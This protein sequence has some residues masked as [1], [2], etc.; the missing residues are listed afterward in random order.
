MN[1]RKLQIAATA[2]VAA[3]GIASVAAVIVDGSP[4]LVA[5]AVIAGLLASMAMLGALRAVRKRVVVSERRIRDLQSRLDRTDATLTALDEAFARTPY[6]AANSQQQM[7]GLAGV[8]QRQ[9]EFERRTLTALVALATEPF[10]GQ[11]EP[12]TSVSERRRELH[13]GTEHV[14]VAVEHLLMT[15]EALEADRIV[16]AHAVLDK[17]PLRL[18]RLLAR[19]LRDRGYLARAQDYFETAAR[20]GDPRDVRTRELRASELEVMSGRFRPTIAPQTDMTATATPG[21]VLHVVGRAVPTTQSGYTLRTHSTARAQLAV[22]LDAHV[23]VQLGITNGG[24][25][26]P[27]E[28]DGVTYHRPTGPSIF[29]VGH[30]AWLQANAEALLA[31]VNEVRPALL[32]AHSDFL[33]LLIANVVGKATQIPVVYEA[34]GFWEESW[35]SRTASRFEWTDTTSLFARFGQPEAYGWRREREAEARAA[36]DHVVTLA[37]VMR[38]RI[39][40]E[41]LPADRLSIVPNAVDSRRFTVEGRDET[42][43][44]ALDVP[45]DALVV[46]CITSIVEYE[47]IEVLIEAF[48][49][50]S[51][52]SLRPLRLLVVGDGPAL[53]ALRARAN[54]LGADGVVFTGRV[55]HADVL[56]YYSLIDIFAV[57][58]RPADVCHLVTPLKPFEA[59]AAG[60]AVVMS[61]VEALKEIAEDSGAATLFSAGDPH[62]LAD[63]LRELVED[64]L[65]RAEM[66]Q[67]GAA[68]V[69]A[70]RSW[71]GNAADYA[72]IYEALT[73]IAVP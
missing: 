30:S 10:D 60:R 67:R 21:R 17:L 2:L 40:D 54:E 49:Q 37:R 39:L 22:G 16:R 15:G 38:E 20:Q 14:L 62:A 71:T 19:A 53:P 59:F 26:T 6:G 36:A 11:D 8:E 34:R 31:V 44:S 13:L 64:D 23:Y 46:G 28:L 50:V 65:H 25:V 32:H 3:G 35:L 7:S 70:E 12:R 45:T 56:G 4:A 33:N 24:G 48:H 18:L 66:A 72:R 41:G 42:L 5:I 55:P 68:W 63:V 1:F 69:Q 43:A 61:D 57:P 47:G 73:T 58:R 52:E 27:D 29:E 9:V 51:S